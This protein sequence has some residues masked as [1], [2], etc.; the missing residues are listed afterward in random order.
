[1]SMLWRKW[2]KIE[3]KNNKEIKLHEEIK[4]VLFFANYSNNAASLIMSKQLIQ[5][6]N[7]NA[8]AIPSTAY[9]YSS[10]SSEANQR[11]SVALLMDC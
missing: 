9:L 11:T 1:M 3:N 4:N 10:F 7:A 6:S 2:N 5:L 8:L